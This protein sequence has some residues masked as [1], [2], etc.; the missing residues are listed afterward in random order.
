VTNGWKRPG[1]LPDDQMC[2]QRACVGV[3]LLGLL[4]VMPVARRLVHLERPDRCSRFGHKT[5]GPLLKT[6]QSLHDNILLQSDS[7]INRMCY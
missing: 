7:V 3:A 1:E 2:F 6:D 4:P 5:I